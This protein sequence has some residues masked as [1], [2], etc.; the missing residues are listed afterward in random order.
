MP[1]QICHLAVATLE[2]P[3]FAN[4]VSL[5]VEILTMNHFLNDDPVKATRV[6]FFNIPQRL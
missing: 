5:N 4:S 3:L 1:V 6:C 2:V